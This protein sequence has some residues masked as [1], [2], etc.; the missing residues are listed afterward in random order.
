VILQSSRTLRSWCSRSIFLKL[1]FKKDSV[2]AS[3]ATYMK[4]ETV[5]ELHA[6]W[7][8]KSSILNI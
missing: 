7:N 1:S 2:Y 8:L 5:G 6:L 4:F 3:D